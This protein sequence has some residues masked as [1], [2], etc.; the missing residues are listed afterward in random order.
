MA[1]F[2][3]DMDKILKREAAKS[4]LG[5]KMSRQIT[6]IEQ[7]QDTQDKA[8]NKVNN[9]VDEIKQKLPK[10]NLEQ[11]KAIKQVA[12]Y[13][14]QNIGTKEI[15]DLGETLLKVIKG[16]INNLTQATFKEFLPIQSELTNIINLLQSNNDQDKEKGMDRIEAIK[17]VGIDMKSF[18][19]EMSSTIDRLSELY[20]KDK[21][22]KEKKKEELTKE[23]EILRQR[24]IVTTLDEENLKLKMLTYNEEKIEKKKIIEEEKEIAKEKRRLLDKE[25][26]LKNQK[27]ISDPERKKHIKDIQANKDRE[28]KLNRRK[29][30]AGLETNE[31]RPQGTMER[32]VR[33]VGSNI[34]GQFSSIKEVFSKEGQIGG[35]VTDV[36]NLGGAF[37]GLGKILDITIMPILRLLGSVLFFLVKS[38]MSGITSLIGMAGSLLGLGGGSMGGIG[39]AVKKGGGL[40]SKVPL[41][42]GVAGIAGGM[43][44]DYA[45]DKATESGHEK[46][47]AGLSVGSDALTGASTGAM[48]GSVVPGVG[49]AIGGAIGG[50]AG[51][52]YG[53]YKNWNKISPKDQNTNLNKMSVQAAEEPG[54]K[55]NNLMPIQN[56]SISNVSSGTTV[57]TPEPYNLDRSYI[58]LNTVVV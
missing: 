26:K 32:M 3:D 29:Q 14:K 39:G 57:M 36:K 20:S 54:T 12:E 21:I 34:T 43:A 17:S 19:E 31:I 24:N 38:F 51:A 4:V 13:Q 15:V 1:D 37:K 5:G 55:T 27:N 8:N 35:L 23:Q 56:N 48:I 22:E 45:A 46:L 16:E 7:K 42:G 28:E 50:V 47:G 52:G 11:I 10:Y 30:N 53:L 44:L 2:I 33:D 6:K 25:E 49:T 18:S 58:N 9:D 41:K 40:L